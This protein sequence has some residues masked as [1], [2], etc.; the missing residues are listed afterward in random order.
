M[1]AKQVET[2]LIRTVSSAKDGQTPTIY[3]PGQSTEDNVNERRLYSGCTL[4]GPPPNT[5]NHASVGEIAEIANSAHN[6]LETSLRKRFGQ[7]L[8][9]LASYTIPKSI[10][11][12]SS[13]NIT[14][15]A[16]QPVAGENDLAQNP[17]DL[18]AERG[19]SM[20]DARH[21]LVLSY[22]WSVPFWRQANTWYQHVLGN[23]QFSGI[24]TVQGGTPYCVRFDRC[25]A[26]GTGA[27]NI[28]V[29][30]QPAK[31]DR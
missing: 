19:R 5:C 17:V 8:S 29:L 28:R 24:F 15:S 31:S 23:W 27:G 21:R 18:A 9:F 3:Y 25:L 7:G 22:M 26:A 2:G 20:F 4:N 30:E 14:G 13:F 16:A 10:D 12:V 1:T 6:A 11:D